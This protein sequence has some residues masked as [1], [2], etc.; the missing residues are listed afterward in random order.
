MGY[1]FLK[2][3]FDSPKLRES[4]NQLAGEVFGISFYSWMDK[5][6]LT[7]KYIPYSFIVDDKVVANV[8]VNK[9]GLIINGEEKKGI[10]IGT[11]MT[12]PNYRGQG[13]SRKLMEH[14]LD[15]NKGKYDLLYLFANKT[16]LDFYPKF[17]LFPVAEKVFSLEA[18]SNSSSLCNGRKLNM[19]NNTDRNFLYRFASTRMPVS[20]TF[21]ALNS[22]ELLMFHSLN[23][24]PGAI[25]YLE[26]EECVAIFAEEG[27]VLHVYDLVF[28]KEVNL[29]RILSRISSGAV[30]RAILHF[31]PEEQEL[32]YKIEKYYGSEVL[33]ALLDNGTTLPEVFKHPLTAQ[34]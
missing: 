16:V 2:E 13:L 1:K 28:Q 9:I 26:E 12:H 17:G 4:F 23:V 29:K 24:F 33:F 11:V 5:G 6:Y 32:P 34:A 30:K 3:Y 18:I 21:S 14:V 22:V 27:E 15:D 25:Y 8:S 31:T 10:Q 20:N 7:S 19:E